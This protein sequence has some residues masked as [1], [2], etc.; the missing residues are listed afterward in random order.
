[1]PGSRPPFAY[2]A[3]VPSARALRHVALGAGR[4]ATLWTNTACRTAYP[5]P[6]G[7]TVSLYLDGGDGV[8]R[9][10]G[11]GK[12]GF[13]GAICVMPQ[14]RSSDWEIGAPFRFAHVHVPDRE[15]R[16]AFAETFDRDARLMS[17][18]E[19]TLEDRPLLAAPMRRAAAAAL[20]DDALAAQEALA[21]LTVAL[22]ADAPPGAAPLRGGL[23]PSAGRR[24]R[25]YIEAHLDGALRLSDLSA[26]AGLSAFHFLRCFTESFG[27]APHAYARRRRV[28]RAARLLRSG[29]TIAEAAAA[30]G[31]SSQSHL[32]RAFRQETG[33]TPARLRDYRAAPPERAGLTPPP[34]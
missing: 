17:V 4:F 23:A 2:L 27:V 32:T 30:T 22:F 28:E 14:G 6:A 18:P 7:H 8:R 12:R 21:A 34:A 31:F 29:C 19:I 3:D 24:V 9:L 33:V 15:L 25:E 20:A 11:A 10:D 1:M 13:T 16:R 26:V 5:D